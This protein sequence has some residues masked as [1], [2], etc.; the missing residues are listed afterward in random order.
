MFFLVVLVHVKESKTVRTPIF[1]ENPSKK[2]KLTKGRVETAVRRGING[3]ADLEGSGTGV[4]IYIIPERTNQPTIPRRSSR[5]YFLHPTQTGWTE[6]W[7]KNRRR[8]HHTIRQ[9][10]RLM[11]P[12]PA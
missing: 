1:L 3:G 7:K 4:E 12:F 9:L 5:V 11:I 2:N 6:E 8:H 10:S